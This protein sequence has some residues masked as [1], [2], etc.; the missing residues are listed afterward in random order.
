MNPFTTSESGFSRRDTLALAGA[1]M[2]APLLPAFSFAEAPKE[3]S[4]IN[5]INVGQENSQPVEIY[6]GDH[7]SG[8]PVVLIHGWPLNGDAFRCVPAFWDY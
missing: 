3:M 5:Y 4:S 2:V 8:S 7:G 1:G 6:F